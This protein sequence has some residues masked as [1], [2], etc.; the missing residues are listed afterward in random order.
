MAL[1]DGPVHGIAESALHDFAVREFDV[2]RR[3]KPCNPAGQPKIIEGRLA[4]LLRSPDDLLGR[5]HSE[6]PFDGAAIEQAPPQA[7]TDQEAGEGV[8][9]ADHAADNESPLTA[10]LHL[11][12]GARRPAAIDRLGVLRHQARVSAF[13]HDRPGCGSIVG[14][15]PRGEDHAGARDLLLE[16]GA[17]SVQRQPADVEPVNVQTVEGHEHWRCAR[18][19]G[20]RPASRWNWLTRFLSNTQTSPS[21][22]SVGAFSAAIAARARGSGRCGLPLGG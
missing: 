14:Q 7:L 5:W 8:G 1:L 12:P 4:P 15:A 17:S 19:V 2:K 16:D 13:L 6:A 10:D 21:R 20:D 18:L 22:I 9:P 3:L 11:D